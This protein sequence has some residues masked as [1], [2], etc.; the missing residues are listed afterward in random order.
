MG[1]IAFGTSGWRGI[2]CED[3][4][5]ENVRVVTQAIA[6]HLRARGTS[7]NGVVIGYDGRFMGARFALETAKV[8]AGAGIKAY[9][10]ERDTPTPVIALEI[11]RR[12]AAGGINFTAS[13]NPYDYNGLKFSPES[14]GPALPE[15]TNDIEKRANALLGEVCYKELTREQGERAGLI[16]MIDPRPGYFAALR[17]LID[18][19]AIAASGLTIAVNPLYGAGRGYL[20]AMLREC[21]VQVVT[22]ND[23]RDPYFGG[24][25]P[26]PAEE[27]ISDFIALVKGRPDIGLGLAT[28]GDADRY[29]VVD[30]DG[31]FF[32]PN[33]ILAL[34][35]DYLLRR[36]KLSGDAARS[37]ATSQ[38]IDAVAAHHG[39]KVVETPVGF[40]FI[41]ELI[42]AG[43]ILIGGEESAGLT[44]RGHVPDKDGILACLLVAEMVAVEKRSLSVLLQ[45]L[46][47]RVGAIYSHR[48]NLRLSPELEAGY[49]GKLATPLKTLAGK[50][51][52]K[53]VTVDGCKYLFADGSWVL[54]RKSGTEPVVRVYAEAGSTAELARLRA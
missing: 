26:E 41:G 22:L 18:F 40:K 19:K 39:Q 43:S 38:L 8:L 13:H 44:I 51:I 32:E 29:G 15:T 6:D 3:F 7:G 10:C 34:L 30:G 33:Y 20:D 4:T 53:T 47:A 49:A 52:V 17:Q 45:D 1:R 12:Q 14:G 16:E 24:H 50:E 42:T 23:H 21:G 36:K 54:F 25:P 31:R 9:L 46:F 37:V 28:D 5:F 35:Y 2:F 11:L 48:D 27:H